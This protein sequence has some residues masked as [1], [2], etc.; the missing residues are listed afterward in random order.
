MALWKDG[1]QTGRGTYL[2]TNKE[3]FDAEVFAIL[4]AARPLNERN[5]TGQTYAV[6]SDFQ[7]AVARI[8]HDDCGPAQVLA[9][10]V[11]ETFYELR[12]RG[13]SILARWT[14][15]HR[16]VEGNEHADALVRQAAGGEEERA[17]PDYLGGGSLSRLTR[18]TTEARSRTT[19]LFVCLLV[20]LSRCMGPEGPWQRLCRCP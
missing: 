3:V 2:G 5:E 19:S 18:K 10:A 11:V 9:R 6:P 15:A 13:C 20:F 1:G 12:G 7:V 14:P 16:G 8:R 4:R 17:D